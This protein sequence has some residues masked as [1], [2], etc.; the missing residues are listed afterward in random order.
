[1]S[2]E[3]SELIVG[4]I[5]RIPDYT[6]C[7]ICSRGSPS[8]DCRAFLAEPSPRSPLPSSRRLFLIQICVEDSLDT[9]AGS[10]RPQTNTRIG[11]VSSSLRDNGVLQVTHGGRRSWQ[12]VTVKYGLS[13]LYAGLALDSGP[14]DVSHPGLS[15]SCACLKL[16]IGKR[17]H[18]SDLGN[19][20]RCICTGSILVRWDSLR[21]SLQC[22]QPTSMQVTLQ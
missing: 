21:Y 19:P 3:A 1:M 20:A 8:R 13:A 14:K 16:F 6:H 22:A 2:C 12:K 17:V 15:L 9:C 4:L 18:R 10:W 11:Y 7:T 5:K